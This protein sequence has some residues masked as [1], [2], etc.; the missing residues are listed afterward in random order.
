[1]RELQHVLGATLRHEGVVNLLG[2]DHAAQRLRTVGHLLGEVQDVRRHAESLGPGPGAAAAKASDDLVKNQQD[3]VLRA[4]LADARK[5]TDRGNHHAGRAREGLHDHG[6]DVARIVQ[7]DHVQQLVGQR[8]AAVFGHALLEGAGRRL[9]VGNVVRLHALPEQLAVAHDA[10][11]RDTA[12]VHA[13]VAL[14]AADQARL[15]ALALGAPVGARH[16]ERGV[17]RLRARSGEEHV[18][19]AFGRQLLDLVGQRK[20]TGVAELEGGRVVELERGF[21]DGVGDLAAAVAQARAPQAREAVKNLAALVVTQI[22]AFGT[23]DHARIGLE[24]AVARERHPVRFQPG[25]IDACG[26]S[27]GRGLGCG[28][29]AHVRLQQ[30]RARR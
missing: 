4:D 15:G 6:G 27:V 29:D 22:G 16:L 10:A 7:G 20:R 9:G 25:G 3:V 18:V 2:G 19:Q 17:G 30:V 5:V 14:L 8:A 13:V 23:D 12:V 24:V 1:M 26:Q 11:D 21:A 28:G